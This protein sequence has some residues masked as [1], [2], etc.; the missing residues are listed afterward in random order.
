MIRRKPAGPY[1]PG[2]SQESLVHTRP[3]IAGLPLVPLDPVAPANAAAR[4]FAGDRR[5]PHL[6]ERGWARVRQ[7]TGEG[8]ARLIPGTIRAAVGEGP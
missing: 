6:R 3:P 8:P 4:L 5:A 1:N 7:F 2:G